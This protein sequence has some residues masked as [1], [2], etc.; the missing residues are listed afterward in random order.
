VSSA[1]RLSWLGMAF[2]ALAGAALLVAAGVAASRVELSMP[3]A[4]RLAAACMQLVPSV[5]VSG[6]VVLAVLGL[7]GVVL[8]RGARAC[9]GVLAAQRRLRGE[10]CVVRIDESGPIAFCV[11]ADAAPQAFCGGLLRP[12]IYVS[13]GALDALPERE[14]RAVLAHEEHHRRRRDPLRLSAGAVVA[15][16]FFFVPAPRRLLE[17]YRTIAELAADD[18]AVRSTDRSTLARAL[19]RFAA[20]GPSGAVGVAPERVDQLLGERARWDL[21][22][23]VLA[24]SL[25]VLGLL[26]AIAVAAAAASRTVNVPM[27]LMGS[28]TL[29]MAVAVI[30]TLTGVIVA[31]RRRV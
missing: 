17:R 5:A 15:E 19:L 31:C 12:R 23:L 9:T 29:V 13:Q 3:P 20:P 7:A 11:I 26:V 28:C 24:G 2:G 30:G 4:E 16:A 18:A 6:V 8:A 14:L 25:L 22:V 27:A 21:P 10:R 1:R